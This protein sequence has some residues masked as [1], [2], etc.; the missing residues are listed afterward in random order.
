M[1]GDFNGFQRECF[2]FVNVNDQMQKRFLI[3]STLCNYLYIYIFIVCPIF[4]LNKRQ[5]VSFYYNYF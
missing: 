3:L 5:E 2:L 4:V 1:I